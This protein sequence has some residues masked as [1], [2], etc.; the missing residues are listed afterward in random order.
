MVR[1]EIIHAAK[2][3]QARASMLA[4]R[5]H[6]FGPPDV[7]KLEQVARPNPGHGEVLVKVEAAGVGPVGRLDKGRKEC[8]ATT[9]PTHFGLGSVRRDR[10]RGSDLFDFDPGNPVFGV[11]VFGLLAEKTNILSFPPR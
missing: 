1:S 4:W 2:G 3:Q 11:N 5:V 8:L 10:C 7:M 9:A 6:E